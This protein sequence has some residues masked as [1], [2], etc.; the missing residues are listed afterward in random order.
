MSHTD[1][2]SDDMQ[3]DL[4]L[5]KVAKGVDI[6]KEEKAFLAERKH[7]FESRVTVGTK[8]RLKAINDALNTQPRNQDG[9]YA[10]EDRSELDQLDGEE[11]ALAILAAREIIAKRG[12]GF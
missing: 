6:S 2:L 12:G 4:V 7:W 11:R 10:S 9:T 3:L 5:K 1:R 8:A